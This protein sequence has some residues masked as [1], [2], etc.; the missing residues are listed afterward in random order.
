ML[1]ENGAHS[2]N[3]KLWCRK[4]DNLSD[5]DFARGFEQLEFMLKEAGREGRELWPPSYAEFLGYCEK[6]VGAAIAA[7]KPFMPGLPEP[8]EH[9]QKRRELGM[10]KCSEILGMLE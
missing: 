5:E 9:R 7:Y 8:K 3:F 2:E 6:P 4:L 10:E 1:M